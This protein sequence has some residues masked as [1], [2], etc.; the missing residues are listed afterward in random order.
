MRAQIAGY[1]AKERQVLAMDAQP[2][3]GELPR[4]FGPDALLTALNVF[5]TFAWYAHLK[6]LAARPWDVAAVSSRSACL[7]H[8][9]Q[10]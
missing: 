3:P 7:C 6:N 10:F 4:Q 5:M 9:P 2:E 8:S 1:Q